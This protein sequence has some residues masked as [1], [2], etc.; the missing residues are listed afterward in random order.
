MATFSSPG[1]KPLSKKRGRE[2]SLSLTDD[3]VSSSQ[4]GRDTKP[5]RRPRREL[6]EATACITGAGL[7]NEVGNGRCNRAWPAVNALPEKC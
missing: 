6:N 5:G 3:S 4:D 1:V 2:I 7:G